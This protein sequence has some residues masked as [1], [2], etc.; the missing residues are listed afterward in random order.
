MSHEWK[1]GDWA[2]SP[3]MGGEICRFVVGCTFLRKN[4]LLLHDHGAIH[5]PDC[6][7]FDWQPP[8]PIELP[9]GYRSLVEGEL[10]GEHDLSFANK[11]WMPAQSLSIGQ[12]YKQD[13]FFE[14]CRKIEPSAPIEPPSG[15]RLVTD[16]VV[17]EGDMSLQNAGWYFSTCV[18]RDISELLELGAAK[19]Y[20]RKIAPQYRQFANAAEYEPYCDRWLV[21]EDGECVR[22]IRIRPDAKIATCHGSISFKDAFI[23]YKFKDGTPFGLLVNVEA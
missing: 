11:Q 22:V 10:I 6:D 18:G 20:A 12:T 3:A 16:G 5:L 21:D 1:F 2:G 23:R 8:A 9:P 17:L 7:S 4:G 15:Y 13:R 19:A 14:M